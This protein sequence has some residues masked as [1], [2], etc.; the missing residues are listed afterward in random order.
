MRFGLLSED[1][2]KELKV[3]SDADWAQDKTDRKSV[4]AYLG[5]ISTGLIFYGSKKQ[6]SVTTATTESE[7]ITISTTAKQGQ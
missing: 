5:L 1:S 4:S 7:Y 6:T 3:Y 2:S